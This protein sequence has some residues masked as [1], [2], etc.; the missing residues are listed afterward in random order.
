MKIFLK[1]SYQYK[2]HHILFWIFY[3]IGWVQIYK[4]F[5]E[6]LSDLLM[7]TAAYAIAHATMYYSTQYFFIPRLLKKRKIV[8]FIMSITGLLMALSL[9][10]YLAIALILNQGLTMYG[11]PMSQFLITLFFSIVFM[12]SVLIIIKSLLDYIR[13]SRTEDRK[14]KERLEA[15]LQYLK[16]QVNPHF[17]FNTINSVY[18]L[19]N[20][21]PKKASETLIKLSDLLRAQLYDFG[22]DRISIEQEIN[23]LEN[24]IELERIRKGEKLIIEWEK[25]P[26]IQGFR[27]A[28]L[29][30][31]PFLENCFKHVGAPHGQNNIIKIKMNLD[32]NKFTAYFFNTKDIES[33]KMMQQRGGIG[34]KNI[35]RR[36]ELLYPGAYTLNIKDLPL[37]Y[38]ATLTLTIDDK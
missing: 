15:E 33:E 18:V 5:Y 26:G 2:L 21:N 22:M 36:L 19:I 8:F 14:E 3:Y 9:M 20:Q 29:M 7:V 10:L 31:M 12:T 30:L 35:R 4:G 37:S 34:M 38:E 27:I 17:L 23:Y 25:A 16:A 1:L 24:Y 6:H 28:P 11:V 32:Q 13:N